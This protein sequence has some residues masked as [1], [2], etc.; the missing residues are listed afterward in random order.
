MF[1]LAACGLVGSLV[2]GL[3]SLALYPPSFPSSL[4]TSVHRS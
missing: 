1:K 2:D 4:A 3:V